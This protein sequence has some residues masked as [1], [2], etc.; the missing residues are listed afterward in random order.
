M[1]QVQLVS[2]RYRVRAEQPVFVRCTTLGLRA[3]VAV[4]LR[5]HHANCQHSFLND[6][7]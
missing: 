3:A 4:H 1:C 5:E 6:T 2:L 7:Q